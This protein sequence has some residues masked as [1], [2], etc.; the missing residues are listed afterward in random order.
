MA[1]LETN[2]ELGGEKVL[3]PKSIRDYRTVN[4]IGAEWGR[5]S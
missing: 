4:M 5:R 2:I 3:R 1:W